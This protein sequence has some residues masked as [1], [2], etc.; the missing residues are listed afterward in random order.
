MLHPD[1][2]LF[3][4]VSVEIGGFR[5]SLDGGETWETVLDDQEGARGRTAMSMGR[6][7]A[8]TGTTPPSRRDSLTWCL[9]S[10]PDGIYAS[11][12]RGKELGRFSRQC[13]CF[14]GNTIM[15]SPSR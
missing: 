14:R 7:V 13:K 8:S 6:A 12:D 4:F 5:R 9:A 1:D 2:P 11:A 10:T 15:T 3:I